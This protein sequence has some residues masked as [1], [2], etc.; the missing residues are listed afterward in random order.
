MSL[1]FTNPAFVGSSLVPAL[2]L[3]F[4]PLTTLSQPVLA[5]TCERLDVVGGEGT[6]ITKTVSPPDLLFFN[7]NWNTDFAMNSG[8]SYS[9][10]V[11]DF[12]SESGTTYNIDVFL[13][14]PD[15]SV[16]RSYSVK[17]RTVTE[18]EPIA[19]RAEARSS[20]DPYQVNLRVGGLNS[21]GNTYT[22]SVSGCR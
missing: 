7:N 14:Y 12:I 11:V 5:Q 9:Y 15:D 19:I 13:K 4:M 10:F 8:R 2:A 1:K 3:A 22:A 18:G 21:G 16:D 20:S 6:E 17:E